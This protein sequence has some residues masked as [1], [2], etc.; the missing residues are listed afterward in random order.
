MET[1]PLPGAHDSAV[2][3]RRI[4]SR[5]LSSETVMCMSDPFRSN[6]EPSADIHVRPKGRSN[7]RDIANDL[8]FIR[9]ALSRAGDVR[10][11]EIYTKYVLGGNEKMSQGVE[12]L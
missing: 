6:A 1:L 7:S 8:S 5:T 11:S 12:I 4:F 2:P 10:R 3:T 9:L